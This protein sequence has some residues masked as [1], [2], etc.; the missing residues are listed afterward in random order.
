MLLTQNYQN[1]S[2]LDETTACQSCLVFLDTV[3][4][5][6]LKLLVSKTLK[7]SFTRGNCKWYH[8]KAGVRFPIC[9][10]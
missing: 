5:P 1:Q 4:N 8:S 10:S 9:I 2:I 6:V 7:C 3:Y